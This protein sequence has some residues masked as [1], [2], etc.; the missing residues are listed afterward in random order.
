MKC[1]EMYFRKCILAAVRDLFLLTTGFQLSLDLL[2]APSHP[3]NSLKSP[4]NFT[5][6]HKPLLIKA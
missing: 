2:N 1:S 4:R 5:A 3:N 6:T